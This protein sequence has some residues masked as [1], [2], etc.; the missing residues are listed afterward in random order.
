EQ[1]RRYQPASPGEEV[2][3]P[4]PAEMPEAGEEV[5]AEAAP[6]ESQRLV[7]RL[8]Q[9]SDEDEDAN[10]LHELLTILRKFPGGDGVKLSVS[11]GDKITNLRLP[12]NINY[13][14]ELHQRLA[15]LVG[16]D[17]LKLE[18]AA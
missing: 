1:A 8:G 14:P 13:C 18:V 3:T 16:E 10:R 9:T 7:I 6:V 4:Q 12:G 17:G 11:N 5:V 2:A 15:E